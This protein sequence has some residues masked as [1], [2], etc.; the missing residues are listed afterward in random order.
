MWNAAA[1]PFGASALAAAV[2]RP[3]ALAPV[4]EEDVAGDADA[5]AAGESVFAWSFGHAVRRS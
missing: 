4:V 2:A 1:G 3:G 5:D